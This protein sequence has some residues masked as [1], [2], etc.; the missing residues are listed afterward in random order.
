MIVVFF[1]SFSY[2]FSLGL[3]NRRLDTSHRPKNVIDELTFYIKFH[4]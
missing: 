4:I 3:C 2:D 1:M